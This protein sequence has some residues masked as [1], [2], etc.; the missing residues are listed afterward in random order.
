[1]EASGEKFSI[2]RLNKSHNREKFS[3]GVTL[4]D[5]YVRKQAGQD[6][7][8]HLSVT[9]ILND[10][11]LNKVAGY[12]TLSSTTI[13]LSDLPEK[14]SKKLPRYPLLPATLIGRL[15]IDQNYQK[16]GLG[17]VLLIDALKRANEASEAVASLAVI[18]EAIN[19][20]ALRF[21]KKYNF[22]SFLS[23]KSKLYLP[24]KV[25]YKLVKN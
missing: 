6:T 25:I 15:A 12:Y 1:M 4:L 3:C 13:E 24:M 20:N 9:Y 16:Q 11:M 2:N 14:L 8:K 10:E 17:E 5:D 7:R 18:V 23:H 22:K 21:Y 19:V